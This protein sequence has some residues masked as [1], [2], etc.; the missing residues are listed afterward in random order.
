VPIGASTVAQATAEGKGILGPAGTNCSSPTVLDD[1]WASGFRLLCQNNFYVLM[2]DLTNPAIKVDVK[3]ASSGTA[4][5]SSFADG[6]TI[7]IINADYQWCSSGAICSQGLTVSNG[8]NPT[9]YTNI[10]HL[11]SDAKVRREIGFSQDGR[12]TI[13]WWYRFV[14]DGQARAWCGSIPGSGGGLESYSYNLVGA[15]PQFTFDGTFHWDCQYGQNSSTHN[16]LASGGDVGI[17]GEHFGVGDWWNRPQ[18]VIGYSTDGSTLVLGESNNQSHTMQDVHDLL[19]Q[20]LSAYGKTLKNAFKFDGG[21]KAGF[22]YYNSAYNSTPEYTVP[23]VIRIQRTNSTCYSLSVNA[24]PGGGGNVNV[25]PAPNCAQ[26]KYTPGT[27]VQLSANAN[28]GYSFSNWS[29][30]TS[31]GSNPVN[32]TL[33]GNRS[34]TANFSII[35]YTLSTY[36]NPTGSGSV[37]VT[38][39]PNCN[40]SQYTPGTVVQLTA[41][42]GSGYT[43][44]NWSGDASGSS[45]PIPITMNGNRSVTASFTP[46]Q[47]C[48]SLTTSVNPS[49]SGSVATNPTPNCNSTQYTSGTIVRLTASSNANY[50]FSNWSGVLI[51]SSN[52]VSVTMDGNKSVTA[53]FIAT[54]NNCSVMNSPWPVYRQNQLRTGRSAYNGPSTPEAKWHYATDSYEGS[55]PAIGADGT[56]F[57][58]LSNTVYA[59]TPAGAVVW[60][61]TTGGAAKAPALAANGTVYAGSADGKLYAFNPNGTLKWSYTTGGWISASPAIGSDGTVYIGSSD[62]TF[63]AIDYDGTLKWSYPVGSW[64]NS[65]P[66]IGTDGTI[67]FGSST[68]SVYALNRD[69]TLRWRYQTGSYVDATPAIGSDGTV[70]IGSVDQYFYALDASGNL[71]WRYLTGGAGFSAA[72]IAGDGTVSVGSNDGYLYALQPNGTLRWRYLTQGAVN[73]VSAG[74]DGTLYAGSN[75]GF[76]YAIRPDGTLKWSEYL[77]GWVREPAIGADGTLYSNSSGTLYA[78]ESVSTSFRKTTPVSGTVGMTINPTLSWGSSTGATSYEYCYDVTNNSTCGGPWVGVGTNISVTLSS[79]NRGTTY[80]WQVRAVSASGTTYADG[81]T[82]WQFTTQAVPAGARMY[83]DQPTTNRSLG[84]VFTL[85]IKAD[86]GSGTADTVDAYLN[87]DPAYLQVVDMSG[88]PAATIEEN[89]ALGL[90][91]TLNTVDNVAGQINFSA[92][93]YTTPALSGTLMVATVRLKAL[94]VVSATP[95][96]FVRSGGRYSD[97]LRAGDSL[98]PTLAGSAV[99]VAPGVILNGRLAL[100]RRGT[101]GDPRWV[102]PLYRMAS[103][104]E[105]T[106]GV[107][108]YHAGT[109]NPAGIYSATTDAYGHVTVTLTGLNPGVY[110]LQ[111]KSANTLSNKR[112]SVSLPAMSEVNFGTLL[113]GDANGNDAVN[114]GDVSYMIPAFTR[115]AG[116]SAYRREADTNGDGCVN[117]GDVS[118]LVPNYTRAGPVIVSGALTSAKP[119]AGPAAGAGLMLTSPISS[120]VIGEV[121]T[122]TLVVDTGGADADTMDAYLDFDPA[123]LE[124]VDAAGQPVTTIEVNAALGLAVTYNAV[125]NVA[126]R[127][128][129]S[130][131]KLGAPW[132][133]G[134]LTVATVRLRAKARAASTPVTL[135]RQGGRYSDVLHFGDSLAPTRAGLRLAINLPPRVFL[136][137]MGR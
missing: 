127:I 91:L 5:V 32:V 102:T 57:V 55:A 78:L 87:F 132:L 131:S 111:V 22:W 90:A 130:V 26:N 105:V 17:N 35:C 115:C 96:A 53:R 24:N 136:P 50:G 40:G 77:S 81:D 86:T 18:S 104:G 48:Y 98:N 16:C 45:N 110:D 83:L 94:A 84:E 15:G 97:L 71:K 52:P 46:V 121:F 25:N 8:S 60:S 30:D 103:T 12:V 80:Y 116:D 41:T 31:G 79:L 120:P 61:Y 67:Y 109:L 106:G 124:V 2:V 59:L 69:G 128:G 119:A 108:V 28:T 117:G 64:I 38:P 126:G 10:S 135:V 29:G 133:S 6:N 7:A 123:Y 72:A 134:R 47:V 74:S 36:I 89:S 70:Y 13:D 137:I 9:S 129:L 23:N 14:S 27:V 44:A 39:G 4:A 21:S 1:Q 43:F 65:S 82:W 49:G 113:V 58:G 99:N 107:R 118:A 114:G 88:Q 85:D 20:R 100:E 62:A 56:V 76:L 73:G 95:V 93:K 54:C 63:Y 75:D 68:G 66:A 19:Y 11:C 125:D 34:V 112:L 92:S 37:G 33:N 51:G 101:A 42:A 122:A 3:A